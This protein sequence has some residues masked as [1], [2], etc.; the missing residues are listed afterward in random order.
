[1][2]WRLEGA[3]EASDSE[4]ESKVPSLRKLAFLSRVRPEPE[5]VDF[6]CRMLSWFS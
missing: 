1:M 2:V 3:V 4:M 5:P 6:L